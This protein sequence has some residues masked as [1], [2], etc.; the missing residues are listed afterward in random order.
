MMLKDL[1][2]KNRSYRRFYQNVKIEKCDLI[3]L[4]DLARLSPSPK[5][6]QIIRFMVFNDEKINSEIFENLVWAGYLKEWAGP[7]E[8]E[9]P[10]AYIIL[11]ADKKLSVSF[12]ADLVNTAYGI[13]CQSILLGAVEK[14]F[15]GCTIAALK[16]ENLKKVL[17]LKDNFEILCVIALGKPKE[18][19]VIEEIDEDTDI[20]YYRDDKQ[21][22]HVPKRKLQNIIINF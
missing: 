9:R 22:H 7:V 4:V 1:I 8:G 16:K 5:N 15:G 11:L 2:L 14:G 18:E 21:R 6:K 10:S 19:I 3:E 20:K 13:A 17:E 12:D